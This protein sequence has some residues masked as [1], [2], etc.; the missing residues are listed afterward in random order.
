MTGTQLVQSQILAPLSIPAQQT[1]AQPKISVSYGA[2]SCQP[3][4]LPKL[5]PNAWTPPKSGHSNVVPA[6]KMQAVNLS[7]TSV[8]LKY[9]TLMQSDV[10]LIAKDSTL[11]RWN[12]VYFQEIPE[13]DALKNAI[14]WLSSNAPTQTTLQKAKSCLGLVMVAIGIQAKFG[15]AKSII[16]LKN[17]Y[18]EV[19]PT[20]AINR[21]A[22]DKS[23]LL[24]YALNASLPPGGSSIYTPAPV[25]VNSLFAKYLETSLPDI[26]VRD[27]L[28]ELAGDTLLP[29]I[30]YQKAGL[31]KGAGSNGKSVFIKLLSALHQKVAPM[32]LDNLTGFNLMP[33]LGASLVVVDEVPAQGINE[34]ILKGLISGEAVTVDRKN[35]APVSFTPTAKW[36]IS[37]NND[38]KLTDN[39]HGFWRRLVVIPFTQELSGKD[40]VPGLDQAIITNELMI[41]LDWCLAGLQR[42]TQRGKYPDE[43]KAVAVAK[44]EATIAS[45]SVKAWNAFEE[46]STI[47]EIN[48]EKLGVYNKYR[49]WC[50][51]EGRRAVEA[52]QFWKSLKSLHPK[53]VEQ[54]RRNLNGRI[55]YV[56]LHFLNDSELPVT[57]VGNETVPFDCPYVPVK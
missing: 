15:V 16:P 18:L 34:Q 39:S 3:K 37:T 27:F 33:L 13:Q 4:Y 10:D 47:T 56:N 50:R 5:H 52:G 32:R 43:P 7:K 31:L 55:R 30:L 24:T 17:A 9:T 21:I 2:P 28:Q 48:Q 29:T 42:L 6:P 45:D 57:E 1:F 19:L 14:K 20:G 38:Q 49:D 8:E 23:F 46:I 40:I 25:P 35:E 12:G 11:Y 41:F 54:Q 51:D 22:P 26:E 44:H 36:I 53:M